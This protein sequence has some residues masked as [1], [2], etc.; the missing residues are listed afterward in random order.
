MKTTKAQNIKVGMFAVFAGALAVLVLL[1]FG[2]MRFWQHHN[3]YVI[4]VAHSVMGLQNGAEVDF[5]GI[6]VGSVTSIDIDRSDVRNVRVEIEVDEDTPIRSDTKALIES[7]GLTG[8]K[9]VDLIGGSANAPHLASNSTI[10]VGETTLDKFERQAS[11]MADNTSAL[12]KRA[13]EVVG[14]VDDI[15]SELSKM[16]K[17]AHL[18]EIAAQTRATATNL[19]RA[20]STLDTMVRENRAALKSSI[21]SIDAAARS[22]SD[23]LDGQVTG[24][25]T[26]VNDLV[27]QLKAV[28]HTDGAQLKSAMTDLKQASRSFKELARDVKAKPSRLLFADP[29]ADRK[30]P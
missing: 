16:T 19:A 24:V 20:S 29:E 9:S 7:G 28:V 10:A 2:G 1:V 21:A 12:S 30:L 23:L 15:V 4:I 13:S 11:E 25:V 17:D 27:S 6:K 3:H 18:D 22:T 14:H 26:N 8:Q 5:N